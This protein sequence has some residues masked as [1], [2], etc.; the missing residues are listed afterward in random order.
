MPASQACKFNVASSSSS[1]GFDGKSSLHA[2]HGTASQLTGSITATV[3]DGSLALDPQPAMHV[4]FPVER[5]SSGNSLQ[6]KEMW[7][8]LDSKR[9]PTITADLR[10]LASTGGNAYRATG[11]ISMSGRNKSY[12]GDLTIKVDRDRV[13][14]DGALV[15]DIRDFGLQPPRLLMVTVQPQVTVKLHLVGVLDMGAT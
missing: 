11:D 2:V 6:D 7:K 8:L 10:N 1:L 5:M 4:E 13:V 15:V 9:N 3:E 12:D 14:V